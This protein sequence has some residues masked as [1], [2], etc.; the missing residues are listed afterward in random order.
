MNHTGEEHVK[1]LSHELRK[2][3]CADKRTRAKRRLRSCTSSKSNVFQHGNS[4]LLSSDVDWISR[5]DGVGMYQALLPLN[6]L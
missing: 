1:V 2:I 6:C 5:Y 3:D 4:A